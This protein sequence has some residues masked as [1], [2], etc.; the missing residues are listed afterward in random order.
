VSKAKTNCFVIAT[1][2][3]VAEFERHNAQFIIAKRK[4]AFN[5]KTGL[6]KRYYVIKTL[7]NPAEV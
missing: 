3:Q 7:D 1:A 4:P 2:A 5:K 6:I